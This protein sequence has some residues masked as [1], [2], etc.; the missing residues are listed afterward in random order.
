MIVDISL[1]VIL[2][3]EVHSPALC[4]SF[5]LSLFLSLSLSLYI[6]I[7]KITNSVAL[8]REELHQPSDRR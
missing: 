4:H 8:L 3:Y 5:F 1:C 6:Y 7:Y 2:K